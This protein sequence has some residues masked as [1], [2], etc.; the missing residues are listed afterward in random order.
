MS[1]FAFLVADFIAGATE[2]LPSLEDLEPW[3]VTARSINI[4]SRLTRGG[5]YVDE[6]ADVHPT[7]EL[8][9]PVYVGQGCSIG[10]HAVVRSGVWMGSDVVIGPGVEVAR[11]FL[12]TGARLAHFNYV[13]DSLIGADVNLEAGAIIANRWNERENKRIEFVYEDAIHD[14]GGTERF[15]ALVG[16]GV[17][18][19]ANAVLSPGTLLKPK[20]V[21]KRLDLVQQLPRAPLT[22]APPPL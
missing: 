3:D 8:I 6:S 13:G 15:G 11:S 10:P 7:A 2:R 22:S 14:A 1:N 12:F 5:V 9:G 18:I 19:G 17:R 21:I 4:V 20:T 16:D